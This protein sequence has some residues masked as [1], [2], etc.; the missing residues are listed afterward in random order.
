MFF[1]GKRFFKPHSGWFNRQFCAGFVVFMLLGGVYCKAF[2]VAVLRMLS[3]IM[4]KVSSG[5]IISLWE[6]TAYLT[7]YVLF[8][9]I[10]VCVSVL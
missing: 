1:V 5:L 10:C 7:I 4:F 8:M 9:H 2:G 3:I 6:E